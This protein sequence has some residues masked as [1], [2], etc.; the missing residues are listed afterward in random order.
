METWQQAWILSRMLAR[1][2]R[3]ARAEMGKGPGSHLEALAQRL[4]RLQGTAVVHRL[5]LAGALDEEGALPAP[6]A[7]DPEERALALTAGLEGESRDPA[8]L[9]YLVGWLADQGDPRAGRHLAHG[10]LARFPGHRI[11][12]D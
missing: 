12:S 3:A 10:F 2:C 8:A 6:L 7:V 5:A 4:F 1:Q 11:R 9:V